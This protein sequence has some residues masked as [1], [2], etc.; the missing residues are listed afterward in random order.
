MHPPKHHA[1]VCTVQFRFVVRK[2]FV[3]KRTR[4]FIELAA[5][6]EA[7]YPPIFAFRAGKRHYFVKRIAAILRF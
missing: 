4:G 6:I 7:I 3:A 2:Y 1:M 5:I